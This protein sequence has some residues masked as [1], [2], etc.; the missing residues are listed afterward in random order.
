M[1]NRIRKH[2]LAVLYIYSVTYIYICVCV[3]YVA[4]LFSTIHQLTRVYFALSVWALR[5]V[6]AAASLRVLESE[7]KYW[8][9]ITV[10]ILYNGK[11]QI[12]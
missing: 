8:P 11:Y 2:R 4:V 9:H 7:L 1:P 10:Y 5:H 3:L 12:Q 6:S